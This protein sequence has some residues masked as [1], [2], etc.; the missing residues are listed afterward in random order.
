MTKSDVQF[1][2][3]VTLNRR[4]D[5]HFKVQVLC[6]RTKN[7][8]V[9]LG[10]P[11]VGKTAIVEGLAIRYKTLALSVFN[12]LIA[13]YRL[14]NGDVPTNLQQFT[15]ISLDLGALI[16]GASHRGEFEQRLKAVLTEVKAPL[17]PSEYAEMSLQIK[18]S[19][20]VVLFIDE[21]HLL[22]GAGRAE[23]AMDAANLLKPMLARGE[24]RCIGATVCHVSF[25]S[26]LQISLL[27]IDP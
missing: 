17:L 15:I 9:L 26:A 1:R 14:A 18:A 2:Y 21:I 22:L 27:F 4:S 5:S 10:Q 23:G 7:N 20:R 6:R 13:I 8:P 3:N 12:F 25:C 24:L 11:G 19:G 16:A